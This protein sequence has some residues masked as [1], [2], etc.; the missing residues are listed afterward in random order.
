MGDCEWTGK[1]SVAEV[2][3]L[4]RKLALPGRLRLKRGIAIPISQG[5]AR[6][7]GRTNKS[8]SRSSAFG[9]G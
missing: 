2:D 3:V 9:E 8:K 1:I 6:V 5:F 7:D 4:E